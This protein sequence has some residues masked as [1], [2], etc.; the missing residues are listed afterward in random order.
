LSCDLRFRVPK[1]DPPRSAEFFQEEY[2]QGFTTDRPSDTALA[3]LIATKFADA[4]KDFRPYVEVLRAAGLRPGDAI[5][6]FGC[7]WGY[8]SWQLREAGFN[9]YSYEIS[10]PRALYAKDK[11]SCNIVESVESLRGRLKCVFSA[12]VIEHLADP[13]LLWNVGTTTLEDGG[14]IVCFCPNGDPLLEGIYGASRYHQLW[15]KVHPLLV[16]S[17][18]LQKSSKKH[19]FRA[20]VYR[21]PYKLAAIA[22]NGADDNSYGRELCLIAA[23]I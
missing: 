11:L 6:D 12:H 4:E 17:N 2:T 19:G 7:S 9:V 22:A 14:L 16:T 20:R 8:G 23:R 21:S 3:S 18:F 15:G 10:K 5:L 13:N 1:D